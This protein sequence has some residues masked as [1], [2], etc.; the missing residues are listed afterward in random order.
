MA[1]CLIRS[2]LATVVAGALLLA[3]CNSADGSGTASSPS[4][5]VAVD[6]SEPATPR[7]RFRYPPAPS[8]LDAEAQS[9]TDALDAVATVKLWLG[10][11]E[12]DIAAV[13][14]LGDTGDIRYGWYLSDVLYFSPVTT[15][16]SSSMP[17]NSSVVSRLRMIRKV[18]RVHSGV[19]GIT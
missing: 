17:S 14:A 5:A 6:D 13:R 10:A 9:A 19:S 2:R 15:V 4:T 8:A 11:A 18:S 16:S 12:L 1:S 7:P 3:A